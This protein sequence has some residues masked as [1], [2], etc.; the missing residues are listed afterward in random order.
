MWPVEFDGKPAM[1]NRAVIFFTASFIQFALISSN[2]LMEG[3]FHVFFI[4]H[5]SG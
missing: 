3:D 5:I 4:D 1:A 2:M